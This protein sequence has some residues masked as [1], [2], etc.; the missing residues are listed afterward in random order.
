MM[1]SI[2]TMVEMVL[3]E[4][5]GLLV[6][7]FKR[8]FL[9]LLSSLYER[10]LNQTFC[11]FGTLLN[12]DS[13]QNAGRLFQATSVTDTFNGRQ[14]QKAR[15]TPG[16]ECVETEARFVSNVHSESMHNRGNVTR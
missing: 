9:K 11:R 12:V 2:V 8:T 15:V 10:L 5:M 1:Y 13:P 14:S 4:K 3:V 6:P 7:S 16:S